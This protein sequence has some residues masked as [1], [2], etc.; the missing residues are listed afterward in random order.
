MKTHLIE[1]PYGRKTSELLCKA[2]DVHVLLPEI[3]ELL[4]NAW[5]SIAS[6]WGEEEA[7]PFKAMIA[8]LETKL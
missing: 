7:A 1:T 3:I 8:K 4:R 2:M 5:G 6:E